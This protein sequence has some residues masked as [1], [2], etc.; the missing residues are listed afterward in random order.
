LDAP[1]ARVTVSAYVRSENQHDGVRGMAKILYVDDER[2]IARAVLVWLSRKGVEVT[3]AHS[4]AG[5]RRCLARHRFDGAF[6]DVWLGDGTGFDL[7]ELVQREHPEL[8]PHVAFV[9]GDTVPRAEVGRRLAELGR[10]VLTKPF[11]LSDLETWVDVWTAG[12]ARAT[13][14]SPA[15]PDARAPRDVPPPGEPGSRA[16]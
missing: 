10:P 14:A 2:A 15:A 5:A 7:Y 13:P 12:P 8:A 1:N 3:R 16:P 9:T 4:V 11:D 6:L